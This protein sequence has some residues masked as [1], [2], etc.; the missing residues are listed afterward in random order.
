MRIQNKPLIDNFALKHS[1][2][3]EALERWAIII[4]D[5]SWQSHSDLKLD[6]P[7]ADYVGNRR[8]VFN[9]KGNRYRVVAI[10]VFMSG[11]LIV[12]FIGKH[13]DYD[14]IDCSII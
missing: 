10:V 12:R 6:F 14:K 3:T 2:A 9:I 1:D 8:Y 11:L 4:E 7:S 5:A 13:S